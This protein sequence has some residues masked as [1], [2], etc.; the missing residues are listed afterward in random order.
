MYK[1]KRILG[2]IPAR[3]GSKGLKDKNI[4]DFKGKPLIA[5]T[6]QAALTTGIIDKLIVSTDS[7]EYA[8][9]AEKYGATANIRPSELATDTTSTIEVI[10][11]H[12]SIE[13]GSFDY[14]ILLQPTSPLRTGRHI[15]EAIKEII[16]QEKSALVSVTEAEHSP[17]LMGTLDD[18]LSMYNFINPDNNKRRQD[19]EK[20]YR[21]NGSIYIM[22]INEFKQNKNFYIEN[23]V[24][25]LMDNVSSIDIDNVKDFIV[26]ERLYE[27]LNDK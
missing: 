20:H 1:N 11:Y 17:L 23:S 8:S 16:E 21:I 22:D 7:T 14:F 25:Y 10:D 9:I 26:A 12:L 6:I 18:S 5:Y 24:A 13:E 2:I 3:S 19:L 27:Y 4:K 15:T